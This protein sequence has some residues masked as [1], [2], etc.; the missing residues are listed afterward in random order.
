MDYIQYQIQQLKIIDIEIIEI[1]KVFNLNLVKSSG[2][3]SPVHLQIGQ[4]NPW[5]QLLCHMQ[6]VSDPWYS[7]PRNPKTWHANFELGFSKML[8]LRRY[9][10]N[11]PWR[12]SFLGQFKTFPT[13]SVGRVHL[14][15]EISHTSKYLLLSQQSLW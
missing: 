12:L 5:I 13:A 10:S 14:V 4:K 3:W 2:G 6:K 7:V 1:N 8:L 9:L 15:S 11:N